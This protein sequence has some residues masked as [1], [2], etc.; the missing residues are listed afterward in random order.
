MKKSIFA[1]LALTLIFA[2]I[3]DISA[4]Y[5]RRNNKNWNG[6]GGYCYNN[7]GPL[8][9]LKTETTV[10]GTVESYELLRGNGYRG[11]LVLNVKTTEGNVNVHL[12]PTWYLDDVKLD[13]NKGDKLEIFGSKVTVDNNTFVIAS[14]VK[15]NGT[16]F[17]LRDKYG[18]PKWAGNRRGNRN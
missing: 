14:K 6:R 15:Q 12:G 11:G 16:D 5:G 7:N 1:L 18:F 8:Y 9:D 2:S 3:S 13:I 17:Q 10:K 4:Q